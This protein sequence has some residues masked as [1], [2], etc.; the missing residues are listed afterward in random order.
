MLETP[1]IPISDLTQE[2]ANKVAASVNA[3]LAT[4]LMS[5]FGD[6][7][8]VTREEYGRIYGVGNTYLQKYD[9]FLRKNGA[10]VGE[11]KARRYNRLFNIHT[12]KSIFGAT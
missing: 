6:K 2:I 11:H 8:W 5:L 4:T 7:L 3:S 12:G 9:G 1:H 10:L